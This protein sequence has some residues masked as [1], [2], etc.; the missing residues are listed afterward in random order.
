MALLSRFWKPF[1]HLLHLLARPVRRK[2][3]AGGLVIHAYR[4]YGSQ[5]EIYLEGRVFR[6]PERAPAQSS[7]W[8][9]LKDLWRRLIRTG[10]PDFPVVA[11]FCGAEQ[12]FRTDRAGYFRVHLRPAFPPSPDR[13][14]HTV[15]LEPGD[16]DQASS[17]ARTQGEVFIPSAESRFAVVSDIDDTVM[18]T[19]VA[20]KLRMIK[21]LFLTGA[22]SRVAFTGVAAFYRALHQGDSNQAGNPMI[23]VS[24]G[25][26][27]LYEVIDEF[28][29][30]HRI[31][32]GPVLFLRD[33]G[34]NKKRLLPRRGKSHKLRL[35]R[36]ML[37]IYPELPFLLIGDSGQHDPDVYA[38]IVRE[39]PGRIQ[40]IYIRNVSRSPQRADSIREL[41]V[42]VAECGSSLLLTDDTLAM[43]E[44]AEANGWIKAAGVRA[45]RRAKGAEGNRAAAEPTRPVAVDAGEKTSR[46]VEEGAVEEALEETATRKGSA[47][48]V[49][50]EGN[51][52][53]RKQE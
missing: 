28:F 23:Y 17:A 24:R 5:R 50:V 20:N 21:N 3:E 53:G 7:A 6:Q 44:H 42:Q 52:S 16:K 34:L 45:V 12:V 18:L 36:S 2:R 43:A 19:G 51:A 32:V 26:W 1:R 11:S 30:I 39:N 27:S 40:A 15:D 9:D 31:P 25:P 46:A 35:V 13:V 37:A 41:A 47:P 38:A 49:I 4:G 29:S 8:R 14:W 33:W 22:K 48:N 10:Q